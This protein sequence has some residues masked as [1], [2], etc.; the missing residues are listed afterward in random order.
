M[1]AVAVYDYI[2]GTHTGWTNPGYAWDKTDDTY[3]KRQIN[4]NKDDQGY[5][6]K[7]TS[8]EAPSSGNKILSVEIGAEGY[9]ENTN[10]KAVLAPI[11]GG[12]LR[13]KFRTLSFPDL[14]DDTTRYT[15][16]TDDT[17]FPS[18][19]WGNPPSSHSDPNNKWANEPNAYDQDLSTYASVT[20]PGQWVDDFLYLYWSSPIYSDAVRVRWRAA[21]GFI[22]VDVRKDGVWEHVYQGADTVIDGEEWYRYVFPAGNVDAVRIRF[23]AGADIARTFRLW[24]VDL[25]DANVDPWWWSDVVALDM[26]VHGK[27]TDANKARNLYIDQLRVRVTY[28]APPAPAG[29]GYSDGLVCVQVRG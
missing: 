9:V 25:R 29:Y 24:E 22:D 7:G 11:F 13:G 14:D 28:E 1:S 4:P 23:T 17:L 3:A 16:V 12:T 15:D 26:R 27:N 2:A 21:Q 20:N 8:N 19:G 6:L 18:H 10:L 5:P